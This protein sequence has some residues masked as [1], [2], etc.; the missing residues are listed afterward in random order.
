MGTVLLQ[1]KDKR[2]K[3]RSYFQLLNRTVIFDLKKGKNN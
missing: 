3:V 2:A 1:D